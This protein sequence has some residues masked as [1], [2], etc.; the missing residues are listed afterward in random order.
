[1]ELDAARDFVRD[2]PRAILATYMRS[3]EVQMSPVLVYVDDEGRVGFS[4]TIHRAKTKNLQR[5]PRA[6][7]CVINE[8][9]F[10]AWVRVD[11]EAEVVTLPEAMDA[12]VDYYR[13]LRGEHDDWDD[14]RRAMVEDERC[15]VRI[16]LTEAVAP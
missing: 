4:T 5:D 9:F 8:G 10:G 11:G 16:T 6:S 2:N 14:Y 15:M 12:L 7:L 1:M 13:T 3:G